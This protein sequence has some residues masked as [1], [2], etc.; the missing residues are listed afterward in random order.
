MSVH[1]LF[2]LYVYAYM[3]WRAC[4]CECAV[5][6]QQK[7]FDIPMSLSSGAKSVGG[8]V[9]THAG[10][11]QALTLLNLSSPLLSSF[12]FSY[13]SYFVPWYATCLVMS[14]TFPLHFFAL[15][16]SSASLSITLSFHYVPSFHVNGGCS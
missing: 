1:V 11:F 3:C 7:H 14:P 4:V 2:C 12:I 5:C 13:F 15:S 16:L 9:Q 10:F 6:K 8:S